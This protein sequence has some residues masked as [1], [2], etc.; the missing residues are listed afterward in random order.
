M[1]L[2]KSV[3]RGMGVPTSLSLLFALLAAFVPARPAQAS[4]L[5]VAEAPPALLPAA[6]RTAAIP[7]GHVLIIF[8]GH[9]SF[10]VE[11]PAGVGV[12]TDYNGYVRPPRLPDIVTMNNSHD[13][14]YSDY[15]EPGVKYVL[16]GW[17][18][19][20]GVAQHN[21]TIRDTL[22]RNVPTNLMEFGGKLS[23][24]NSIFVV[25]ASNICV[26]HLSHVHHMLSDEQVLE[27][28]R[29]DVLLAPIDGVW[30]MSHAE[31]LDAILRIK[32][33]L[34]IPMHYGFGGH[35]EAFV[36]RAEKLYT[37]RWHDSDRIL[38]SSVTLPSQ[39]EILFLHGR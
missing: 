21:V 11:S 32:P 16:R 23:N 31:V 22:V 18:P 24:Q 10:M 34:V 13:T 9:A 38:V 12:F 4:C 1:Y 33:R 37:V 26:V 29:V 27:L 17:D 25:E 30:T 3:V 8:S 6:Y 7:E 35:V 15:V 19:A 5:P 28:G 36:D 2:S 39:T 14:H 20:G